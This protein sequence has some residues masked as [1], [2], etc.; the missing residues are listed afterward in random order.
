MFIRKY[1]NFMFQAQSFTPSWKPLR[2]FFFT[3]IV[4]TSVVFVSSLRVIK[5]AERAEP[6]TT[7]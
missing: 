5:D 2:I 1:L 6:Q 4:D 3:L 7:N